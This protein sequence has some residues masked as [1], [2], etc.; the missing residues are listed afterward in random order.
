MINLG[1]GFTAERE[2]RPDGS[3]I[4]YTITGP[5]AP[6]CKSPYDGR[7]AGLAPTDPKY[8]A[9]GH[10]TVSS[11]DPL[12][13]TPSVRCNCDVKHPGEG[14]HGFVTAGQWVNAGGITA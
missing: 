10:W 14:Q 2:E 4:G 12:T 1:A 9:Q 7:C 11:T 5:A 13:M 3:E 6:T 8:P